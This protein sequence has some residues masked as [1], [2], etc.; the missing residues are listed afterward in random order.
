[1][2][3]QKT[4]KVFR[5]RIS[6][7]LIIILLTAF[8]PAVIPIVKHGS[9]SGLWGIAATLMFVVFI[10]SGVRYTILDGKLYVKIWII[11]SG[12]V[13]IANITSITRSYNPLS[14]P[15]ASLKRMQLGLMRSSYM[16]ISPVRE[17]EFIEELKTINPNIKVNVP[18]KKGIWR[19]HDWD[20]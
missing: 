6:V 11:P 19:I 2:K 7:L 1:M 3:R 20:I 17:L 18:I 15:A 16:L 14:S 5:S 13:E 12:S 8:V 10:L 9:T 4:K